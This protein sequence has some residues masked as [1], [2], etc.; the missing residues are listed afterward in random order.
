MPENL[1]TEAKVAER[2]GRHR[3]LV[4]RDRATGHL[5]PKIEYAQNATKT[6]RLYT[7]AEVSRYDA[8][9][10]DKNLAPY[11]KTKKGGPKR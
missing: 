9:L 8:W 1:M 6:A 5:T 2:I 11:R 10:R 4:A 7:E 3:Y